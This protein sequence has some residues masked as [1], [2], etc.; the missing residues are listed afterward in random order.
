MIDPQP[1]PFATDLD[2]TRSRLSTLVKRLMDIAIAGSVLLFGAPVLIALGLA[3]K[4]EDGG[5][6]FF[7]QTRIGERGRPF[8][9]FKFRSMVVDAEKRRQA[10]LASSDR[11]SVCFKMKRDPRVTRVGTLLRRTSLDEIPQLI[12]VLLGD[13]AVVGPRPALP[14]EVAT[15]DGL[16]WSR[17]GGKPGLTCTWQVS[18]RAEI[19]FQQ[20]VRMDVDYLRSQSPWTDIVLLFKTVPAVLSGRGAY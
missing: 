6:I 5:P 3:I 4:L 19:P 9:M 17:L 10:L 20:Q 18:G 1:R 12:N 7:R 11:D 13:M 8:T 15:Y 16:S 14:V 2:V